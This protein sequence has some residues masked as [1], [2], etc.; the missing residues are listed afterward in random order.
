MNFIEFFQD[1]IQVRKFANGSLKAGSKYM[2]FLLENILDSN[3]SFISNT[4]VHFNKE[5]CQIEGGAIIICNHPSFLDFA[6]VKKGIDCYCL[7]DNVD[8]EFKT[9]EEYINNYNVIPY[10]KDDNNAG[11]NAKDIILKCVMEGKKVLVFP[12]GTIEMTEEIIHFK[13][14]LFEMAYNNSIPI[15]SLNIIYNSDFESNYLRSLVAY[16]QIPVEPPKI[17][18]YFNEIIYPTRYTS[19]LSFYDKC[20]ESV[21]NGYYDKKELKN[22]SF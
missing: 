13:K 10:F 1:I 22:N 12:E 8:R 3:N 20:F 11:S 19:F 6:I 21:T 2:Q 14:G 9:T 15:V 5:D 4:E 18:L 17:D 16:F 7:T